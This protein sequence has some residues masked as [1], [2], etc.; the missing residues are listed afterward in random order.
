M[1]WCVSLLAV[2]SLQAGET[3]PA[4]EEVVGPHFVL[5]LPDLDEARQ[6]LSTSAWARFLADDQVTTGLREITGDPETTISSLMAEARWG[7]RVDAPE[8]L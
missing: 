2:T 1:L 8:V 4:Q 3:R 5:R 6:A 7:V